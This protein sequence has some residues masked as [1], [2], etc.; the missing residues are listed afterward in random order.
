MGI[1]PRPFERSKFQSPVTSVGGERHR[2]VPI[3]AERGSGTDVGEK[4]KQSRDDV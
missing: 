4:E 1:H 2:G 3:C